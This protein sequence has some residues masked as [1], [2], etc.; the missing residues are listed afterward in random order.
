MINEPIGSFRE[1]D[2]EF[3]EVTLLSEFQLNDFEGTVRINRTPQGL[4]LDG[5]FTGKVVGQCVR[6]LE[7]HDQRLETEFQELFAYHSRHTRDEEYFVPEDGFI[8]LEPLVYE[9]MIID[10]P[11]RT[12]CKPDCKGLCLECGTNLNLSTCEHNLNQ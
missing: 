9:N 8:D 4:L 5:R 2:F 11:I 1:L 6:C 7:D 3:D 10:I 12:L